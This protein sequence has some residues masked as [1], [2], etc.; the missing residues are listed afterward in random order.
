[1]RSLLAMY[2]F[3]PLLAVLLVLAFDAPLPVETAVILMAIS[4]GAPVLPKKLL[5][6]DPFYVCGEHVV[7]HEAEMRVV[8]AKQ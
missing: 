5:K 4:A 1:V 3:T 7:D 2:V 8:L 6:I